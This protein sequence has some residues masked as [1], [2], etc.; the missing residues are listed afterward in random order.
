MN[1]PE[2]GG[3]PMEWVAVS[4]RGHSTYPGPQYTASEVHPRSCT[5]FTAV[6][7]HLFRVKEE[8]KVSGEFTNGYALLIGVD[9]NYV[10]KW[11][12]P[13]VAKDVTALAKVLTHPER[14]A[15]LAD[16]VKVLTGLAA[17][18]QGILDGLEWL[19]GCIDADASGNTTAV[20][21]YSGHGWRDKSATPPE[22]YFIPYDVRESRIRLHALRALDF[23]EAVG[24]LRTRRLLVVLDCCHAAGMGVKDVVPL[25]AGYVG[26][27]IAPSFL[28][29]GEEVSVAPSAEGVK[30]FEDLAQGKGRAVLS[31]STGE[32]NSYIRK[33]RNMSIFTYHLIEALTGH[34]QPQEGAIEVL[35]SDVMSHVWRHVPQSAKT[36]WGKEQTPDYQVSGNFPI[37][38]LLGGK[39]LSKGQSAPDPLEEIIA[40][41]ATLTEYRIDTGDSAY[42][43]GSVEVEEGDFIGRDKVVYGDEVHGDKVGGDKIAVGDVSGSTGVAIGRGAQATVTREG[44]SSDE[45]ANLFATVY[46]RIKARPEDPDVDKEELTETVQKIQ[47]EAARGKAANPSKIE[48]WLKTLALMASDIFDVTV[49]CLTNPVAGI[50][51]VICKVAEKAREEVGQA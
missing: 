6:G 11:A 7:Q 44:L 49:A 46:Q 32:Q 20:I 24:E 12:L 30:G 34:A 25:P 28:M 45:I 10:D 26:A 9:E 43:G 4:G 3:R 33:D 16:N 29:E 17:T 13:D 51:T 21:Y 15:Y 19:Q 42:I 22:F 8:I 18:R 23:A 31:S 1:W 40:G 2:L 37:A 47:E 48:R 39:G 5:D 38:L 50:A 27:A 41:R 14:C 36:D 35:V